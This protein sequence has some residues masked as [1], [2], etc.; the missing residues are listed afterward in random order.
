[1]STRRTFLQAA[2]AFAGLGLL[3]S[4]QA[5][6]QRKQIDLT[7]FCADDYTHYRYNLTKPFSQAG[8]VYG[9]DG[10]ICCRTTLADVPRLDGATKLPAASDLPWWEQD[11]RWQQWP[12]QRLFTDGYKYG[13]KCPMCMGRGGFEP[14]TRCVTCEG[15]GS[16]VLTNEELAAGTLDGGYEKDCPDCRGTGWQTPNRCEYCKGTGWTTRACLQ[17]VGSLAVSGHYHAKVR[18]LGEVEFAIVGN[19]RGTLYKGAVEYPIVK[20]RGDGFEGLLMPIDM[21]AR[22]S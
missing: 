8:M 4:W 17:R 13:G 12:K 10:S 18:A 5:F 3:P 9:T 15:E 1:M 6:T 7:P 22:K 21:E 2:G 20:F 16:I 14:L 11:S 19:P